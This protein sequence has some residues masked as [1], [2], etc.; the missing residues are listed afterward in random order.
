MGYTVQRSAVTSKGTQML[1][2]SKI[3]DALDDAIY[4]LTGYLTSRKFLR[5]EIVRDGRSLAADICARHPEMI[6]PSKPFPV[7]IKNGMSGRDIR[8][9][10]EEGFEDHLFHSMIETR[11]QRL[12]GEAKALPCKADPIGLK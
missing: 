8:T 1:G 9:A 2:V 11:R 6:P 3:R 12:Q 4:G 5:G 7:E 10:M